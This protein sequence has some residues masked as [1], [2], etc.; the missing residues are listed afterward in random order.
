M[1]AT[2]PPT[3][4]RDLSL[5]ALL[6]TVLLWAS[7]FVGIRDLG[8]TFSPG[9]LSLGRLVVASIAL[10]FIAWP[11]H[12]VMPRGNALKLIIIYGIVWFGAYN[13]CLNAGERYLDAG[14]SALVVNIGPILIALF[15][16]VFLKE[17]FPRPLLI[18]TGIAFAGVVLIALSTHKGTATVATASTR[19]VVL[20]VAAAVFYA[21]G[22]LAQKP[23]L[24]TT[25]AVQAVWLGCIVGAVV[26]LPYGPS[27]VQQLGHASLRDIAVLVY[28]GVFPTAIGFSTWSYALKRLDAGKVAATTYL[29]PAIATLISWLLLDETPAALAFVGGALCLTGV[30]VTRLRRRRPLPVRAVGS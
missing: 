16:G 30:A 20:C 17:G 14:T 25:P 10:S 12:E 7:A 6:V 5:A 21:V 24:R 19:G 3:T 18:G 1:P 27:L 8:N 2:S 23:A 28:L 9:A 15:A 26:C 11:K 4:S 29:V 13:V 22:V